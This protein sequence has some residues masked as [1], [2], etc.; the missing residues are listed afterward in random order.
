MVFLVTQGESRL[1][2]RVVFTSNVGQLGFYASLRSNLT[3]VGQQV[4]DVGS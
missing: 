2:T 3:W 1:Q 4:G